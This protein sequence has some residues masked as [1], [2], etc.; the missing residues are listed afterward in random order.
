MGPH[1][2]D[3]AARLRGGAVALIVTLAFVA[4]ARAA[5]PDVDRFKAEIDAFV[6][7]LGPSSNDVVRWVGS[8]PYEI[9]RDGGVLVALIT[10]A[11]L[12]LGGQQIGGFTLDRIEIRQLG[13]RED[14]KLIELAV[15]LPREVTLRE[16]DGTETKITL[17][18]AT[19]NALIE[20][21]SGRG[22]ETAIAIASARLEQPNTGAWVSIGP[23]SMGSKL[24][25]EPNGGWSGPVDFEAANVE[26]FVPQVPVGGRINRLT[27]SGRNAGPSLA[28]LNEL[29]DAIDKLQTDDSRSPEARGAAFLAILPTITAPF[30]SMSGEFAVDGVTVR[31]LMGEALVTLAKAGITIA[32]TGLDAE[33]AAIRFG[34]RHEGFELAPSI[35]DAAK[36]PHRVVFDLGISDI[37][38]HALGKLVR[39]AS[40]M[41]DANRAS[42]NEDQ[43]K[44]RQASELLLGAAAM[45]DPSFHIYDIAIATGDVG[46]DLTGEAKGSPL[47]PKGYT[48]AGELAV[49]GFD[50][51]PKLGV[52]LPFADYLPILREVGVEQTA[53]DGTPRLAFHLASAPPKWMTINGND[54]GAWFDDVEAKR[55]QARLLKPADPPMQGTD[56]KSVQRALA[57]AR[58]AVEQD[59]VYNSATA[60]AVARFQKQNGIN[61][62]GVVDSAT[63][64][65]LGIS[66][67]AP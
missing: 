37:S 66:T 62:S 26:Y 12:S 50:A 27:F 44:K 51:I 5:D 25:A 3:F 43:Q 56:V 63:R 57:A 10:N 29:R 30:G 39:A 34:I 55:G 67:N 65:R 9:R 1:R 4:P 7:R 54:V 24:V 46:V 2:R 60:A 31:S 48:A 6:G 40:M 32:V 45:L 23:L 36:V 18:D 52:Q 38:T 61:V 35:L 42:E 15:Q 28:A 21:Q 49:R 13:T 33:A 11:R 58:I 47:A 41:M 8:D 22:R 59:G 64:Q 16:A 53:P 19:A 17:K 20:P 14:G